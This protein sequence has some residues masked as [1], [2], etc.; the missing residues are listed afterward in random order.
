MITGWRTEP[1]KRMKVSGHATRVLAGSGYE[2]SFVVGGCCYLLAICLM[3]AAGK[4][5]PMV[6]LLSP[7]A[8]LGANGAIDPN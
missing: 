3:L 1:A 8:S 5:S 7:A 4:I 6:T 2:V